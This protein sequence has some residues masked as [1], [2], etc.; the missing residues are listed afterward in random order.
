[1][2]FKPYFY[3]SKTDSK[4]EA[5]DHVLTASE[6]AALEYFSG[7]KKMNKDTFLSLYNIVEDEVKKSK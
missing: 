2:K 6:E 4:Q 3:Y 1:M 5:I 7:R